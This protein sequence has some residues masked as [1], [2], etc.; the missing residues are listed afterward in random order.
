MMIA[1]VGELAY[2]TA[3]IGL[4]Q[5]E[6]LTIETIEIS[7]RKKHIKNTIYKNFQIFLCRYKFWNIFCFERL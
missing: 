1:G 2:I 3:L 5:D 4:K 6:I 7:S